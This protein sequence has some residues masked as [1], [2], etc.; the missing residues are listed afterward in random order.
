MR[1]ST[2]HDFR[3]IDFEFEGMDAIL[4]FPDEANNEKNWL[5]K[6]EYFG[7]FQGFELEMV[8][9]GWHL[10][11]VKNITRWCKDEDL[12]RKARF[13]EFLSREYGLYPKCV[14]VGMSCGGLIGFKL[15]ARHPACVSALYLD[16]PV[17]NFLSCPAGLGGKCG[18]EMLPE[19]TAAMGMGL[20]ELIC[21][22]EHPIDQMH[23]LLENKIPIVM[24]YGDSDRTVPYVENGAL[25]EKY[26]RENGGELLAIGK[27]G[28]DHHPHGL[29]DPTPIIEFVEAHRL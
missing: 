20:S 28:C 1:E 7:A 26:Y 15:A 27:A 17:M 22:R 16:A 5:L 23:L 14:P 21:Y 10:A 24:V 2:W 12:D 25:L 11:Y 19:F 18:N 4:V 6:T 3:R 9:R 8:K 13:A 29:E